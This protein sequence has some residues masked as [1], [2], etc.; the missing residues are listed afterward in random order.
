MLDVVVKAWN[1][2]VV[3]MVLVVV[4]SGAMGGHLRGLD[5]C[6]ES[7]ESVERLCGAMVG[8]ACSGLIELKIEARKSKRMKGEKGF[9]ELKLY[10]EKW[11]HN[12]YRFLG[13][14]PYLYQQEPKKINLLLFPT[15]IS[16]LNDWCCLV[17]NFPFAKATKAKHRSP[18]NGCRC[19]S[20]EE[21]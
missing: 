2:D 18:P 16:G 9:L 17:S 20:I 3:E 1:K 21:E 12:H 15:A 14:L 11:C 7:A 5:L 4:R 10:Q 6:L 19:K 8:G 13:F